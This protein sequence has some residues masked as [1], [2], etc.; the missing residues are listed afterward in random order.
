MKSLLCKFKHEPAFKFLVLSMV[1]VLA[2]LPFPGAAAA[3]DDYVFIAEWEGEGLGKGQFNQPS[4]IA[5]DR[6]G[7]VYVSDR[8]NHRVQVFTGS[9]EFITAWGTQGSEKGQLNKPAGI[10]VADRG[11][12]YVS[13]RG[14]ARIQV[15]FPRTSA[16]S[17]SK[18]ICG[19]TVVAI[20]ALLPLLWHR[21]SRR[22][23]KK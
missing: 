6:S 17:Q 13:D 12:V 8:G 5:V 15:F 21:V 22:H 11:S 16:S 1:L 18:G 23:D 9:G 19:P 20:I 14:N 7:N 3:S 10:A 2:A 4:G